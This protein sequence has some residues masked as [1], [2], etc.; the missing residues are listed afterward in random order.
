MQFCRCWA[1]E[2]STFTFSG[3][4]SRVS[5]V[6]AGVT[7]GKE[8][9]WGGEVQ[10]GEER[11]DLVLDQVAAQGDKGTQGDHC[12]TWTGSPWGAVGRE[13]KSLFGISSGTVEGVG[14]WGA[15][16]ATCDISDSRP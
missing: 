6:P 8:L 4:D 3:S 15:S 16:G 13:S 1:S 11:E 7:L 5:V 2:L 12:C 14:S 9:S 10:G